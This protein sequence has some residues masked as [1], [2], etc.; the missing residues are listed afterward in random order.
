MHTIYKYPLEIVDE[1]IIHLP[2]EG[3]GLCVR[4]ISGEIVLYAI[5]NTASAPVPV[6][7]RIF[8]TGA[9]IPEDELQYLQ[10]IDTVIEKY[11]NGIEGAW[12]VYVKIPLPQ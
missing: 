8:G 9:V 6:T 4:S 3:G 11:R 1:Q 7:I 5:V 12:H 10:Y 2:S